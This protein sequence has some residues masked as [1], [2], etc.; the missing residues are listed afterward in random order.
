MQSKS[1]LALLLFG[2]FIGILLTKLYYTRQTER[3]IDSSV[4]LE[5]IKT[6]TKVI[7][8]EGHFSELMTQNSYQGNFGFLWDKKAI[9]QVRAKVSAGYDLNRMQL[10]IDEST[11]TLR[12]KN[13]PKAEILSIDQQ[14]SYYDINE[15]L[16]ESFTAQDYTQIQADARRKIEEAAQ[17]SNLLQSAENQGNTLV[18]SIVQ[19]AEQAGYKVETDFK[20]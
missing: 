9:V 4:L 7:T 2:L 8:V 14:L 18:K 3:V 10:V 6:V 5:Q 17:R 13:L 15:G 1:T 19:M 12:M 20:L 11:H 16:F